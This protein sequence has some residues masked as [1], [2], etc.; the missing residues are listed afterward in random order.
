MRT[1]LLPIGAFVFAILL[2]LPARAEKVHSL[3][4][5]S[6]VLSFALP[7]GG[8]ALIGGT[9]FLSDTNAVH[10]DF[11]YSVTIPDGGENTGGF[12]VIPA[13]I[14][15]LNRDRMATFVKGAL[16][17]TKAA[18]VSFGDGLTADLGGFFGVEFFI[19][20]QISVSGEI[21]VAINFRDKFK[22]ITSQ[23]GTGALF[24]NFY[25]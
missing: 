5:A 20:P 13:I 14:H 21:G 11:G 24:A 9:Y 22:T 18:G 23:A 2:A 10:L 19:L 15:Y 25:F 4:T 16:N 8:G 7:T 12:T 17:L 3:Q 1:R 6:K